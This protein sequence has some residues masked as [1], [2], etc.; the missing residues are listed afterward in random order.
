MCGI[1][2]FVSFKGHAREGAAARVRAMTDAI[3]H[4][5]PDAA[6]L[7]V[8][9]QVALGHRRLAIIDLDGGQQPMAALGGE[10]QI[11][12]NGEVYNFAALRT[13][14]E[15]LGHRFNSRSDTEVV[16]LSYLQWGEGCFARFNGM[17]ALAIWDARTRSLVLARDRTGKKPLY[18]HRTPDGIAFASELKALRAA[19]ACP[20]QIDPEA[21]DCYF[22][23]GYVPAPRSIFRGVRKLRPARSLRVSESGDR[24][25]QYWALRFGAARPRSV[26]DATDEFEELLLSAV[27]CRLVSDVPLGAFLS[28]GLDSSLVVSAMAEL[29][30]RPVETHS[31]GPADGGDGELPL[32]RQV[33]AHLGTRHH[34]FRVDSDI[35]GILEKMIWHLDEPLADSSAVPTWHVSRLARQHVTVAL[36]GDGGDEAFG[37]YTSR[38]VPHLVESRWRAALPAALRSAVFGPLGRAWPASARLPRPLRL[39]TILGNLAV[40]DA[41]A[42]ARDLAWLRDE[43]RQALYAP[44]LLESLRG[45]TPLELVA[46]R[47]R[48]DDPA[49]DA[50]SRAQQADMDLYMTDDVLAKVDRM[51]MAHSLEVRCPLLDYRILEFAAT[52]PREL[53]LGMRDGKRVL[54]RAAERRLPAA[55]SAAPKQGFSIPA[56]EWL[57]GP[58]ASRFEALALAQGSPLH[59]YIDPTALRGVWRE[60]LSRHRDHGVTLWA[61][62][63]LAVWMGGGAL[64]R[65]P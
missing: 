42:Y 41:R 59:E 3:V 55:V 40:D 13:E 45:F 34:E 14:L 7:Y 24:E 16:L 37:G 15:A 53:K 48:S 57:R 49:M 58:L 26:E 65:A 62:M 4:R 25:L 22:T 47:Y 8:D 60:H 29:G 5:G 36:S 56:A 46:A 31:I 52:L 32:A 28:G 61:L 39:K 12:F 18:Y 20:T 23:L 30:G 1:A 63:S 43:T 11:V 19:D 9:D 27:Q 38:Y 64:G 10:L 35:D 54:R 50:L 51:S 33:A 17:F 21:L 2:G 44:A 6:G